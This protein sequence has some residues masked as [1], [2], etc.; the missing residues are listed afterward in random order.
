MSRLPALLFQ[1]TTGADAEGEA[2]DLDATANGNRFGATLATRI[3]DGALSIKIHTGPSIKPPAARRSWAWAQARPSRFTQQC[4]QNHT[5][6]CEHSFNPMSNMRAPM[7][8]LRLC[9]PLAYE[10]TSSVNLNLIR[11]D[12]T[13][14]A[15]A[16]PDP[17][18][19]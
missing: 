19:R 11:H 5:S 3:R 14:D 7:L 18:C 9:L 17:R 16:A 1:E 8:A 13:K 6:C 10:E 12:N 4:H 15:A 2:E